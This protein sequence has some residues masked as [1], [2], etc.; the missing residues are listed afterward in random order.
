MNSRTPGTLGAFRIGGIPVRFHFTF[1]LLVLVL[2]VSG[3]GGGASAMFEAAYIA[4]LF[5][6]VI[7]HELGHA[8]TA[9]RFG[10]PTIDI[11]IYPI[12]GVARLGRQPSPKEELWITAAG[13]AVNV[14]IAGALFGLLAS[15][16]ASG[17]A[18]ELV[19]SV[20][21]GNA[22]LAIFNLLP[23]FPMD[24][25]RL[26]R[27]F[28]ALTKGE[29]A[30]TRIAT[31]VGRVIAVMI[32]IYAILNAQWFLL[33]IALFVFMGA[34]Q[35][36]IVSVAR[37]LSSGVPVR[38]AMVTNFEILPH[39]SSVGDA[40]KLLLATSQQDFPVLHGE[41]VLGLLTRPE[42]MAAMASGGPEAYVAGFMS[43]DYVSVSP[44]MDLSLA[45]PM[46]EKAGQTAL[47][48]D[49]EQ[50]LGLL[51]RDNIAE[52]FALRSLGGPRPSSGT[53]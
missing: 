38:D 11:T 35:E 9:R 15:G 5:A 45:L 42:L 28:L 16:A 51:T 33:F 40:G 36:Q 3:V 4:A 39:G 48:M 8:L 41:Q 37:T 1:L 44:E 12:G 32:G 34:Q 29:P 23:A 24:G 49:G 13:P 31:V 50:L 30:A 7:L 2:V 20:A 14:V 52:F 43:R 17:E 19:R 47:V 6:S 26:L 22:G 46:M 18:R 25:G 53:T 10:V 27:A 21:V